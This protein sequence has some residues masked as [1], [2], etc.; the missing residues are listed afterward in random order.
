L[1]ASRVD[2]I[3]SLKEGKSSMSSPRK[4]AF[5]RAIVVSQ[6]ALSLT[7]LITA[8]ML[9]RSFANL[10]GAGTGF[11]SD[12]VLL[13]KIDS[14]SSGYKQDQR[15]AALYS[16]I[17]QSVSGSV[18]LRSYHEGR[19]TE[20]FTVPGVNLSGDKSVTLNFV[21]PAFFDTFRIPLLNGRKFE[22]GDNAAAEPVAVINETFARKAFGGASAVGKTFLMS[23][24]TEKDQAYRVIGV[25]RDVKTNDV[26]D[27]EENLAYLPLAQ[28]PVYAGTIA[29]RV[30]GDPAAV[31]SRV[32]STIRSIEPNL[33]IRFTTTLATEVSDSLVSERALAELSVFFA[34]L[35]LLLSAI[36][37]YGTISFAV[38]RRTS[39]I[40]IRM[41]LGAE[42]SGI[43]G[44]VLRDA[45]TLLAVG[46]AIGLP[47]SIAAGRELESLLYGLGS[48]DPISAAGAVVSLA[49]VAAI[50]GYLPA[51]RASRVDPIVALRYE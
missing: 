51:R 36:G 9:L 31:A 42:R 14:E 6:V 39:E 46:I 48:F 33:P 26:R 22:A 20:G 8:G 5:G 37:L 34:G 25:V 4:L 15:L 45:M 16:R 43:V 50:A 38:A 2:L 35:A 18:S 7:L 49:C 27:K 41:A 21:T 19:W 10:I 11:D 12:N 47:L 40:G 29:V 30:Q 17:A 44:M 13:F 28:A 3:A 23:P 24:L 32:R 1:R